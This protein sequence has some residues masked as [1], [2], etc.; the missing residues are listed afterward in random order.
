MLC[1]K[2]RSQ[3][4][5]ATRLGSR[6]TKMFGCKNNKTTHRTVVIGAS[7]TGKSSLI[8]QLINGT[9]SDSFSLRE[10]S[11]RISC[12]F[13]QHNIALEINEISSR[14]CAETRHREYAKADSV[15]LIY[16]I[17]REETFDYISRISQ[18]ICHFNT[19]MNAS[20]AILVIGNKVDKVAGDNELL[21]QEF[22]TQELIVSIE[23]EL[24]YQLISAKTG[25]NVD[26]IRKIIIKK[27]ILQLDP[28]VKVRKSSFYKF[29]HRMFAPSSS[30]D[31]KFILKNKDSF[32]A[33]LR[34]ISAPARLSSRRESSMD[35]FSRPLSHK[36]TIHVANEDHLQLRHSISN[37]FTPYLSQKQRIA[38][39]W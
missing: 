8:R 36:H 22:I 18:E 21:V 9:N 5:E 2:E 17:N 10:D 25:Y 35:S 29:L 23:W 28:Q 7:K 24:A 13:E 4:T 26:E 32:G 34:K 30:D 19:A 37:D 27:L 1:I 20:I 38:R 33:R 14:A 16:D 31:I 39:K 11:H 3:L 6:D 15:L 12:S